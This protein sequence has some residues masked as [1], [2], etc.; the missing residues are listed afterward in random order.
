MKQFLFC[1]LWNKMESLIFLEKVSLKDTRFYHHNLCKEGLGQQTEYQGSKW[2]SLLNVSM[3]SSI[4]FL[5][6]IY[7]T[8]YNSYLKKL[9]KFLHL[10]FNFFKTEAA[11]GFAS[12]R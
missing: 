12:L 7:G 4:V 3:T 1:F 2:A 6:I 9:W 10:F 5:N 8:W 11:A